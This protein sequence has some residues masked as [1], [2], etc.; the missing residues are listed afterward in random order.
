MNKQK[1]SVI[2]P[3]LNEEESIGKVISDLPGELLDKIVVVDNGSTDNSVK[4]AEE[5]GALVLRE[6]EM[7]YGAACLKGINYL[8][9]NC[10]PEILVF[11]DGDYSDYPE[12]MVN[13]IAKINEGYDFVLGSRVMGVK[14]YAAELSSHSILGNTMAAFF[15]KILFGGKY[16]DMGP[17]RAIRFDRLLDLHMVDRN[18]GWTM[19][20]Q[21]KAERAKLKTIEIPVH[22]RE[23]FGG[24]SKVTGSLAGSIKAFS[25]ITYIVIIYFFRIR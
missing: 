14:E 23:R 9:E 13:L 21:I 25:K 2:I 16:T 7:G 19:E 15:L 1:I 3:V 10:P 22:Y 12:E 4:I 6:S 24:E 18:Y 17:F 11:V 20:M 5:Y 8:K